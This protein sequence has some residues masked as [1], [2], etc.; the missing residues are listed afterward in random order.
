M[1]RQAVI[2]LVDTGRMFTAV[3]IKK[4]DGSER[5]LN[6]QTR[7][8]KFLK[9]G[10]LSF[11]PEDKNLLSVWD[12]KARGYRFIPTDHRLLELRVDGIIIDM[13]NK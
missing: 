9:G 6:G 4:E 13:R 10:E 12:A 11:N 3:F 8:K 7:V 2:D 1:D 5:V